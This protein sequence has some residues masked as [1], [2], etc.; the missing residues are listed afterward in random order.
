MIS[1]NYC[2]IQNQHPRICLISKFREKIKTPKLG[3]KNAFFGIFQLE[4]FK[5]N[6]CHI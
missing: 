2:H 3:T 5:K 1:K 4:F 6:Y